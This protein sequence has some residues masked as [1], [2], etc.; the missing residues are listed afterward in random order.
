MNYISGSENRPRPHLLM[1]SSRNTIGMNDFSCYW[2]N[3]S[4]TKKKAT[5]M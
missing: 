1:I 4:P 3:L 2:K 5:S